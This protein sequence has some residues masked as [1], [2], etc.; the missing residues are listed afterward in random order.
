MAG[1]MNHT[2]GV[3]TPAMGFKTGGNHGYL[4][5]FKQERFLR[6]GHNSTKDE[7]G[8]PTTETGFQTPA[9]PTPTTESPGLQTPG[10][11]DRPR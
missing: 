6:E 10:E 4:G 9:V 7:N 11:D 8:T 5:H 3:C 1:K 2:S